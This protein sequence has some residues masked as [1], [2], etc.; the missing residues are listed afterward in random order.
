MA[1]GGTVTA[2]WIGVLLLIGEKLGRGIARF[3][4]RNPWIYA[5]GT[6]VLLGTVE[7]VALRSQ[8]AAAATAGRERCR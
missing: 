6:L 8:A 2:I 7:V 5:V 4:G 3:T 1:V